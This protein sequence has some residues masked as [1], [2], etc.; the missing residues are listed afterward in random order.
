MLRWK[1]YGGDVRSITSPA[2]TP[3]TESAAAARHEGNE[4]KPHKKN[5]YSREHKIMTPEEMKETNL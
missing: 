4:R 5:R 2:G 3:L 1:Q